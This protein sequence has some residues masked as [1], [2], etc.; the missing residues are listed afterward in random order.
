MAPLCRHLQPANQN[1]H[2]ERIF[3]QR[4]ADA[5]SGRSTRRMR[6][7]ILLPPNRRSQSGGRCWPEAGEFCRLARRPEPELYARAIPIVG[8]TFDALTGACH[9]G[10]GGPPRC[11]APCKT[12]SPANLS[13][14]AFQPAGGAMTRLA[15]L[16]ARNE[17]LLNR[18]GDTGLARWLCSPA[19]RGLGEPLVAVLPVAV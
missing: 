2:D 14:K 10:T 6:P 12:T 5:T 9:V 3:D 4:A 18:V 17:V 1:R 8:V 7:L 15:A 11:A 13:A 19:W 16:E